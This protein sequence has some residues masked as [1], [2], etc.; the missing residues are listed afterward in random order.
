MAVSETIVREYFELH[1]LFV[2]Q[3]RKHI[4]P[5]RE[6]DEVDFYVHNPNGPE[7]GI[8][9]PF[10]LETTHLADLTR[11]VVVVKAWH[12]EVFVGEAPM[13]EKQGKLSPNQKSKH[14]PA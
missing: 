6:D 13:R 2:R 4:A 8:E 7:A 12:T 3:Q 5:R 9:L 10:I 1:G 11:A 14:T